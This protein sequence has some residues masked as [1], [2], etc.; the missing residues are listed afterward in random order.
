MDV[1]GATTVADHRNVLSLSQLVRNDWRKG[2][3]AMRTHLHCDGAITDNRHSTARDVRAVVLAAMMLM[4]LACVALLTHSAVLT[5]TIS[6][7][8]LAAY[9]NARWDVLRVFASQ[10]LWFAVR[11]AALMYFLD[12]VRCACVIAALWFRFRGRQLPLDHAVREHQPR[13]AD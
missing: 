10:G 8:L 2:L 9:I 5:S 6:V 12:L 3:M 4:Q 7:G 11:A 1:C 13:G